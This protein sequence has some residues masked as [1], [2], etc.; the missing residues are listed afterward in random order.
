MAGYR[1]CL[2][3]WDVRTG[4]Y[5]KPVMLAFRKAKWFPWLSAWL[6]AAWIPVQAAGCCKLAFVL[7]FQAIS[8]SEIVPMAGN[9]GCCKKSSAAEAG[10]ESAPF[11]PCEKT[12]KGC[13]IKG[14]PA[15]VDGLAS[16]PVSQESSGGLSLLPAVGE[17]VALPPSA[18]ASPHRIASGPPLYL[19]HQRLLI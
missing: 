6:L 3:L 4:W 10:S 18:P 12:G 9:S 15:S 17:T 1:N 5:I 7:G 2:R 16:T 11:Q 19:A 8:E 13:C 14:A